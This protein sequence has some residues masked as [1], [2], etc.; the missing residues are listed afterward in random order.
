MKIADQNI[1]KA[2]TLLENLEIKGI[3]NATII[4]QV[5]LLITTP[6]E[7]GDKEDGISNEIK[8]NG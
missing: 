4:S 3:R 6:E 7:E 5:A 8:N 1:Q 2:I